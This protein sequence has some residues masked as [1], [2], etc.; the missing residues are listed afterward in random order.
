M[1]YS[2][3]MSGERK[4]SIGLDDPDRGKWDA[5]WSSAPLKH[6]PLPLLITHPFEQ[7]FGQFTA[8]TVSL[9]PPL[10]ARLPDPERIELPSFGNAGV[11]LRRT[12]CSSTR[13]TGLVDPLPRV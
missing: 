9:D 11:L 7:V 5:A 13:S 10:Y 12:P 8:A 6:L 1:G 3:R 2:S 4:R